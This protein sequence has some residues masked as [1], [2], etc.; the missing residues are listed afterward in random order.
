MGTFGKSLARELGKNTGKWASNKVFGNTGHATPHRIVRSSEGNNAGGGNGNSSGGLLS[1][2]G[3]GVGSALSTGAKGTFDMYKG[4]FDDERKEKELKRQEKKDKQIKLEE[5]SSFSVGSEKEEISENL[6]FLVST[7][8]A[9]KDKSVRKVCIE[10]IE[11]GIMK[12]RSNDGHEEADFYSKKLE[13]LNKKKGL[14][15]FFK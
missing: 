6:N 10:K 11:F 2:I 1:G 3:N 7:A 5:L 15:G 9:Q 8:K 4:M 13:E 12:L 14:F